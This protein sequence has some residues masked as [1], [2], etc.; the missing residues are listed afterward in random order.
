MN[1]FSLKSPAFS[2]KGSIPKDYALRGKNHSPELYWEKAPDHT[3]SFAL[4]VVDPD[5]PGGN[6]IHWVLY[7]IPASHQKIPSAFPTDEVLPTGQMQGPNDYGKIGYGGPC[8]PNKE[9]HAYIFTLYALDRVLPLS[10]GASLAELEK[11][12][13]GHILAKTTITGYF[14]DI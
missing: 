11:A 8:P 7:N 10:P 12:L 3:Q 9:K 13:S 14:Q 6:F 2:D 1:S 5:A 4:T